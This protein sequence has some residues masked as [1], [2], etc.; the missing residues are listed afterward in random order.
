MG[1]LFS[2]NTIAPYMLVSAVLFLC[3]VLTILTRRN[4]IYILL[5]V[6]LILNS[7]SLNFVA[8]SRY[9]GLGIDGHIF[10]IFIIILAAS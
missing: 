9:G 5:G 4:T 6:E 2:L 7:A 10:A 8:F 3:G 1:D